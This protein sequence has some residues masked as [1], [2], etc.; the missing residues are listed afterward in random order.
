MDYDVIVIGCGPSGSVAAMYL[1]KVL[2]REKVLLVD[3]SGFPR[4]KICGD[5]QGRKAASVLKELGIYEE[6]AKL[7]GHGIYG[8]TLSSPNGT[9]IDLDVASR[10][11]PP[12]G[13]T[14]KRIILDNFLFE[15]A[16]RFAAFRIFNVTGVI[17]ENGAVKGVIGTNEDGKSEKI[18]SRIVLAGDG[19]NSVVAQQ[20]GLK[21]PQEHMIVGTRQYYK[22]VAGLADRIEIH[23]IRSLIP[24][25]F[26]IFPLA[27]GEANIGLGMIVK[28]MQSKKINLKESMLKEIKE[29]PLF[30]ERFRNA[31]PLEDVRGWNLP[32]ASY[33][34]KCYG[35]GFMLLGDAAS[36]IDPLSGEG[37]G[38]AMISGRLAARVA[39]EALQKN[40]T[41]EGFL[42]KYDTL[43]WDVLGKE[44]KDNHRIQVFAKKFPFMIDRLMVKASRDDAFRKK[45]ESILPFTGKRG[46]IGTSEFLSTIADKKEIDEMMKEA[47]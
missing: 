45:V 16:K 9:V 14:H 23:L 13:F 6:Y 38:N 39:A 1:G 4:D 30:V 42:K 34:R 29:N 5:A 12:P 35:S 3:K 8:I 47:D 18:N 2:G 17:V 43:L 20:L 41:G 36:L 33:H 26:W 27:N 22:N 40:D 31:T 44:I 46:E 21:N 7:P 24:G 19:A 10:S 28:D 32:I 37:V 15:S 11:G 25:Y